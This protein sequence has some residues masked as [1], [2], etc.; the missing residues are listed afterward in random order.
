MSRRKQSSGT[1]FLLKLGL[2]V[3]AA[4]AASVVF[5]KKVLAP[6]PA[7]DYRLPSAPPTNPSAAMGPEEATP[8]TEQE[9]QTLAGA[10]GV[11][12]EGGA[13]VA[14]AGSTVEA[15]SAT[16]EDTGI[17]VDDVVIDTIEADEETGAIV[18]TIVD[19]TRS[20]E[21]TS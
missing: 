19:D 9:K 2:A 15:S 18:E 4:L 13:A 21:H 11:R 17:Q 20:E 1:G 16:D 5:K 8:L 3:L 14:D 12:T 6:S 10:M 7:N